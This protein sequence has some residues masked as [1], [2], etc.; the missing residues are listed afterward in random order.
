LRI[1]A[2][3][4][5]VLAIARFNQETTEYFVV[6]AVVAGLAWSVYGLLLRRQ[7]ARVLGGRV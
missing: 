3:V 1:V 2:L 4:L 5:T 7:R 6:R